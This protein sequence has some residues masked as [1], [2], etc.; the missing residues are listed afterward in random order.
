MQLGRQVAAQ[1]SPSWLMLTLVRSPA[2]SQVA[3]SCRARSSVAGTLARLWAG[4][5]DRLRGDTPK[6]QHVARAHYTISLSQATQP[7]VAIV[8][9]LL[10]HV[11][12]SML[13]L[14][15]RCS[16]EASQQ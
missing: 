14:R 13:C 16:P 12:G 5:S 9:M 1:L 15:E 4:V 3:W 2:V 6:R 8:L 11:A 10:L 7:E